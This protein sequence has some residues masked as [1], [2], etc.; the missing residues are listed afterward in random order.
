MPLASKPYTA[1]SEPTEIWLRVPGYEVQVIPGVND[2]SED[3][4]LSI[5][6]SDKKLSGSVMEA[7]EEK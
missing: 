6:P 3:T 1:F 5:S 7:E 4:K 2:A